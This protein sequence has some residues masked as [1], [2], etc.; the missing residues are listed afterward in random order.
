MERRFKNLWVFDASMK[1]RFLAL[2][3]SLG[4]FA[5]ALTGCSNN[6]NSTTSSNVIEYGDVTDDSSEKDNKEVRKMD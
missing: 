2:V 1:K 4:V 3:L 6:S 5:T